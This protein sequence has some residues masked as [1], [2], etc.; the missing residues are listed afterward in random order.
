MVVSYFPE[1]KTDDGSIKPHINT[2]KVSK[3]RFFF[4]RYACYTDLWALFL[5]TT[6]YECITKCKRLVLLCPILCRRRL[7]T[8]NSQQKVADTCAT[9]RTLSYDGT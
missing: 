9:N 5:E 6:N 2:S 4:G 7:C 1:N 3:T 8:K